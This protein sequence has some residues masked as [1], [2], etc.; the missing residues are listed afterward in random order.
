MILLGLLL[1]IACFEKAEEAK[2]EEP[3]ATEEAMPQ[4]GSKFYM[5][6]HHKVNDYAAWK[7]SF[8]SFAETRVAAGEVSW[9]VL[10]DD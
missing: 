9:V 2:T 5:I 4:H 6:V 7:E 1:P 3:A 8:D 10:Q